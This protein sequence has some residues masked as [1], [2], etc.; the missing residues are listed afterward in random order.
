MLKK[1]TIEEMEA[2]FPDLVKGQTAN[3]VGAEYIF[4]CGRKGHTPFTQ[5]FTMR[6]KS[7]GCQL[8]DI[9]A[10]VAQGTYFK[11]V[12]PERREEPR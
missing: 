6:K 3:G 10:R 12:R 5:R 9:Q 11:A 8:C 4:W 2:R 7:K 1:L